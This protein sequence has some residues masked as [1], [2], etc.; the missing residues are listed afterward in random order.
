MVQTAERVSPSLKSDNVIFQRSKFAYEVAKKYVSGQVL[1]IGCGEG[2]GIKILSPNCQTYYALDKHKSPVI[3]HLGYPHLVFIKEKVPPI[4]S[5]NSNSLDTIVCFQLIEHIED[6]TF[7][8]EELYRVLKPGGKLIMTTPNIKMSLTR[9]PWHCR[10]YTKEG[11]TY[12]VTQKFK[13]IDLLGVFGSENAKMYY[14]NNKKSVQSITKF[15]IL[16]LQYRL[17]RQLLQIPYDI[18][19]R[20]NRNKL[21]KDNAELVNEISIEDYYLDTATDECYDLFCI[22]EK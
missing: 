7:F 4:K 20:I 17:P 9:N 2:Y 16:N 10:E 12:L 1:E 21:S 5:F 8:I 6:D 13:K 18:L 14:E 22:A 3:E 15:D 11:L 19:N